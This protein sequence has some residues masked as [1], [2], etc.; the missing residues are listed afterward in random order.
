MVKQIA[1]ISTTCYVKHNTHS[2]NDYYTIFSILGYT[3]F[4]HKFA[5]KV[6]KNLGHQTAVDSI[7]NS[8]VCLGASFIMYFV[9]SQSNDIIVRHWVKTGVVSLALFVLNWICLYVSALLMFRIKRLHYHAN[10]NAKG[11]KLAQFS[12]MVDDSLD[13]PFMDCSNTRDVLT[14]FNAPSSIYS[15]GSIAAGST[16]SD[17]GFESNIQSKESILR[18]PTVSTMQY[19][20]LEE[21]LEVSPPVSPSVPINQT[22]SGMIKSRSGSARTLSAKQYQEPM[23]K[24]M[25]EVRKTLKRKKSASFSSLAQSADKASAQSLLE[26]PLKLRKG[27]K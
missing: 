16:A 10:A 20:L 13:A 12:K 27:S 25:E 17:I 18:G 5:Q 19:P 14:R 8:G 6:P 4:S 7:V 23:L 24:D 9:P 26:H 3:E 21:R 1:S 22:S 15:G 2:K 11:E